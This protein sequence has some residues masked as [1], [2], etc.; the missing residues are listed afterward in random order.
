VNW[1]RALALAARNMPPGMPTAGLLVVVSDYHHELAGCTTQA[2]AVV[3]ATTPDT[4][5]NIT[6]DF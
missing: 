3:L 1:T 2:T 4:T 6:H 5:I